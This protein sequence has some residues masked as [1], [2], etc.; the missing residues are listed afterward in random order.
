MKIDIRPPRSGK[1][2]TA[3]LEMLKSQDLV[4]V[5]AT[6]D[7]YEDLKYTYPLISDRII[8]FNS[9][10]DNREDLASKGIRVYID[11]L[12]DC[13]N[14]CGCRVVGLS[15]TKHNESKIKYRAEFGK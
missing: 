15:I 13:L 2:T 7:R 11:D 5:V 8:T 1:T 4:L 12:D 6:Q 10:L 3:L 14:T 9:Y